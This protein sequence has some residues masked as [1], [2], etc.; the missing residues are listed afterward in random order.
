MTVEAWNGSF[1]LSSEFESTASPSAIDVLS[2][3]PMT[4]RL[5]SSIFSSGTSAFKRIR[6]LCSNTSCVS[7]PSVRT[8]VLDTK[9]R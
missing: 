1:V 4:V 8:S 3:V 6:K 5:S 7:S 9:R 2:G